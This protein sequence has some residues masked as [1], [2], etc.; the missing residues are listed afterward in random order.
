MQS[1]TKV[2]I[3]G[4]S[5]FSFGIVVAIV[6]FSWFVV[7]PV[8]YAGAIMAKYTRRVL[9]DH[10]VNHAIIGAVKDDDG[11][12]RLGIIKQW[13]DYDFK[14]DDKEKTENGEK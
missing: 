9:D 4:A 2:L 3:L 12:E 1:N 10:R 13:H 14:H 8:C 7:I 6:H 11:K 5:V